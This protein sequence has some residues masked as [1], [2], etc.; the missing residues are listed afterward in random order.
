MRTLAAGSEKA[1]EVDELIAHLREIHNRRPRL[2]QE[3]TR[4][5]LP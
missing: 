5:G 2:Q 1:A 3:F 4:A